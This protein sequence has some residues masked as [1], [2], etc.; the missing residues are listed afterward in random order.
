MGQEGGELSFA[1]LAARK[2][3]FAVLDR[4]QAADIAVDRDIVGWIGE[5]EVSSFARHQLVHVGG[6]AGIAAQQAVPTKL[7]KVAPTRDRRAADPALRL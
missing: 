1:H 3:E 7:P 5:D 6:I 2:G 4:A